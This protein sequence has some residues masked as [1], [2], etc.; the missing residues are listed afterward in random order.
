MKTAQ[1]YSTLKYAQISPKKVAPVLDLVRGK[2]IGEAARVLKF[3]VTKGAK[4]ALKVLTTATA[5]ATN[6]HKMDESK[7]YI[8]EI[9]V[10]GGPMLKRGRAAARGRSVQILKRTSHIVVGLSERKAK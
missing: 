6:N 10:D 7:L 9:W 1:I 5:D 4:L 8:S 2:G 3:D